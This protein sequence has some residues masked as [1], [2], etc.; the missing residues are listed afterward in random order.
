MNVL[1]FPTPS[2]AARIVL[3]TSYL[4]IFHRIG[5]RDAAER[6]ARER[7][8]KAFDPEV[9]EAFVARE[10]DFARISQTAQ[11]KAPE[12]EPPMPEAA[13]SAADE[14]GVALPV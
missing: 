7:R 8:G 3:L 2:L 12:A 9:V 1:P 14:S 4:E 6:L 13:A 10:G 11:A 5:G